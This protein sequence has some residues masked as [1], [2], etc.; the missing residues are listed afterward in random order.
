MAPFV[1]LALALLVQSKFDSIKVTAAVLALTSTA[2]LGVYVRTD[3]TENVADPEGS[4]EQA[5][6]RQGALDVR[7]AAAN[8]SLII[9]AHRNKIKLEYLYLMY[10]SGLDVLDLCRGEDSYLGRRAS[11]STLVPRFRDGEDVY[12]LTNNL[13]FQAPVGS[14]PIGNLYSLKH[15]PFEAWSPVA[16]GACGPPGPVQAR[17]R[18][19]PIS[20]ARRIP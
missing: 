16:R 4:R 14:F 12:L 20:M 5:E 17:D 1:A 10:W 9:L 18:L 6:L 19:Q 11:R 2:V 8:D 7:K 15:V 13:P 3:V